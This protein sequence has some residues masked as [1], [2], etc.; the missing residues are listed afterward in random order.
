MV[1]ISYCVT[2]GYIL[3]FV[4]SLFTFTVHNLIIIHKLHLEKPHR[5]F[6]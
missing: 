6:F 5:S 1:F 2:Y 3:Y 4:A